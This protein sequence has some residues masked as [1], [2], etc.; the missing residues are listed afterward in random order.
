MARGGKKGLSDRE[1]AAIAQFAKVFYS[2][3]CEVVVG[4]S[5]FAIAVA[6]AAGVL[7]AFRGKD[8]PACPHIA[9][10]ARPSA[11][12]V[13][14]H[15]PK[16]IG[17]DAERAQTTVTPSEVAPKTLLPGEIAT[18]AGQI[19]ALAP[20]SD[21]E[22]KPVPLGRLP[23]C[24][25]VGHDPEMLDLGSLKSGDILA[26]GYRGIR[27]LFSKVVYD[28]VWTHASLVYIDPKTKEPYIL[29]AN[30]YSPPY[31]GR[32]VRVPL[33]FWIR[34]NRKSPA[35]AHVA[36]NR[37]PPDDKLVSAFHRFEKLD[38]GIE[39]LKLSWTRF[40]GRRTPETVSAESLFAA[41]H[42]RV[43]PAKKT[44]GTH[45]PIGRKYDYPIACHEILIATLQGAGVVSGRF[46]PCSY[47]PS[48]VA[49]GN[50]PTINGY[51]Y[52][53]PKEVNIDTIALISKVW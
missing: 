45:V 20:I 48:N 35:V 50:L 39:S 52:E 42:R 24:R 40:L 5:L 33:L 28:S 44:R 23:S 11:S 47:L 38:I 30:D 22:A 15:A 7:Y 6:A 21:Q 4:L 17:C 9:A 34:V 43:R 8:L 25:Q 49:N 1:R 46:T 19:T 32:V 16:A 3:L 18:D 12:T 41:D 27:R 10:T 31:S 14:C 26:I 37:A 2:A 51:Y 13:N 29:E 36:I 53:S